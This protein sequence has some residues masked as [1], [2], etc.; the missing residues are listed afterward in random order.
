MSG[1][2]YKRIFKPL[3]QCLPFSWQYR[4]RSLRYGLFTN[5]IVQRWKQKG[6]PI[7]PPPQVKHH[8]IRKIQEHYHYPILVETGT[9]K[10]DT[11]QALKKSFR[12]IYTIE[13]GEELFRDAQRRFRKEAH[14]HVLHGDSGHLLNKVMKEIDAPAIFWLDGHYSGKLTARGTIE[15]PILDEIDAV[16]SKMEQRHVIL[17]DDA[18]SFSG[19]DYPSLSRLEDHFFQHCPDYQMQVKD[20]II[21][22]TPH[23]T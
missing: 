2:L 16:C 12:Q 5:M 8:I 9:Y 4:L 22:F 21:Y 23:N 10:G 15:S 18:R 13:I 7:P 17:I 14:I 19:K 20:D 11:I 3:Y 6:K 1:L